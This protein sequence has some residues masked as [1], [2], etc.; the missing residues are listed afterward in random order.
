MR[1]SMSIAKAA[2]RSRGFEIIGER[3]PVKIGGY[4]VS[5][6]DLIA[7]KDGQTYAIEVK[8]G[9]ADVGG[10]RQAYVNAL[11]IKAKPLMVCRGFSDSSAEALARELGIGVIELDDLLISDPEELRS[12]I[13]E[14]V[15]RAMMEV[16]PSV[17][18]PPNLGLRDIK[19]L[20][21]V[22]EADSFMEAAKLLGF[23]EKK[24]GKEMKRLRSEGK[25]PRWL[26][27]Y[28]ELRE[29]T[30]S[31]IRTWGKSFSP[32]PVDQ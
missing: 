2:L 20:R 14:E 18:N 6:V 28:S 15:R 17:L 4:E 16:L 7:K 32:E 23:D 22:A 12:I 25:L 9:R 11:L 21:A 26:R 19:I 3:V 5:D 31:L 8:N 13:R 27:D 1:S 29:W 10:I 24:L 30:I